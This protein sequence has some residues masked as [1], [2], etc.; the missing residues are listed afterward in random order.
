ML[1]II[2]AE[3]F[4][5]ILNPNIGLNPTAIKLIATTSTIKPLTTIS[6]TLKSRVPL[7]KQ[8]ALSQQ[9][10]RSPVIPLF[11]P[12]KSPAPTPARTPTKKADISPAEAK[13][14]PVAEALR[15]D[16][17]FRR[18]YRPYYPVY[19]RNRRRP[20]PKPYYAPPNYNGYNAPYEDY[21]FETDFLDP[22]YAPKPKK[23][24]PP[25]ESEKDYGVVD[26]DIGQFY[27]SQSQTY[28]VPPLKSYESPTYYTSGSGGPGY[29]TGSGS[30]TSGPSGAAYNDYGDE[31]T[32][33]YKYSTTKPK[34]NYNSLPSRSPVKHGKTRPKYNSY[35]ESD[36]R[37]SS[38]TSGSGGSSA[39][40]TSAPDIEEITA[41][42]ETVAK[43]RNVYKPQQTIYQTAKQKPKPKPLKTT[44]TT[45]S[46]I[47]FSD[48]AIDVLT[49]PLGSATFNLNLSPGTVYN[50]PPI[51]YN[52]VQANYKPIPIQPP[53]TSYGVPIAPPLNA[54]TYQNAYQNQY[55]GYAPSIAQNSGSYINPSS[56]S[57]TNGA[58][59][60]PG[61][62]A[63]PL[64]PINQQQLSN[65]DANY[66]NVQSS[67]D[68]TPKNTRPTK[69]KNTKVN[70]KRVSPKPPPLNTDEEIANDDEH[71]DYYGESYSFYKTMPQPSLPNTYDQEEF[72]TVK[73][74]RKQS[75]QGSDYYYERDEK[76]R[77]TKRPKQ[78][79]E[80]TLRIPDEDYLDDLV[81]VVQTTRRP[82]K[83]SRP[84][85]AHVLDTEDLRDAYD[86]N[87]AYYPSKTKK[88]KARTKQPGDYDNYEDDNADE[89]YENDRVSSV[90][91]K[92]DKTKSADSD[93]NSDQSSP[94]QYWDKSSSI[95]KQY[96]IRARN[97]HFPIGGSYEVRDYN[98]GFRPIRSQDRSDIYVASPSNI[99]TTHVRDVNPPIKNTF[100]NGN[101][102][103]ISS[104]LHSFTP[105]TQPTTL[106]VWD[107]KKLPRNHKLA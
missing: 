67:Y 81:K 48:T 12:G 38:D 39:Y 51:N 53:A 45:V 7:T 92:E 95:Y 19:S 87:S 107:G 72:H 14:A 5:P 65:V 25:V 24:L 13:D 85:T 40:G 97:D 41:D 89:D 43:Y 80:V 62:F 33:V 4:R 102:N 61:R 34:N 99:R 60:M 83:K 47:K 63:E 58:A 8:Q 44:T 57:I 26:T 31:D 55:A 49:K 46:P 98:N 79:V 30:G 91:S 23:K 71:N 70:S 15:G 64:P 28:K 78:P 86:N 2:N 93:S 18:Y 77:T 35:D 88:N 52:P 103:R 104:T 16:P 54:Y 82:K 22:T 74:P 3:Q 42:P 11:P 105:T 10:S 59:N 27:D 21:R 90:N 68:V 32:S 76:I 100:S 66:N 96:G 37:Y 69:R 106:F 1:H 56:I 94:E 17:Y 29:G 73:K 84:T 9:P 20:Y 75:K 50:P 6:A 36:Y 101:G